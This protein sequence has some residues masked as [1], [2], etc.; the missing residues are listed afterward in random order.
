MGATRAC[1]PGTAAANKPITIEVDK[2]TGCLGCGDTLEPCT[3]QIR[4]NVITVVANVQTCPVANACPAICGLPKVTCTL[5]ALAEG[6]F[7]VAIDGE[8][9]HAARQLVVAASGDSSCK[10]PAPGDI[11]ET[12]VGSYSAACNSAADCVA[13]VGGDVCDPCTCPSIVIATS[14]RSQYDAD[15]RAA[16]SHCTSTSGG[17]LCGPCPARPVVCTKGLTNTCAFQ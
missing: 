6:T 16:A 15:Y 2:P 4:G 11:P 8:P 14:A 17:V 13:V 7:T 1:V 9:T 10:L 12:T 3:V 5:P